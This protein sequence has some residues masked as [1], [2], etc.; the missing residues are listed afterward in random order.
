VKGEEPKVTVD[1]DTHARGA[2]VVAAKVVVVSGPDAGHEAALDDVLEIGSH[3]SCGLVLHDPAVS[4]RHVLIKRIAGKLSVKDLGSRNGTYL[5][6]AR[7]MEAEVPL[8]AVLRVGTTSIAIQP[9]WYVRELPPSQSRSFG[10]L[11]G[12]SL[13]MR[14]IFSVLERVAATGVTVLVEGESG[15]GKELA[16]RSIHSASAR[17]S[18][19]YVVFDCSAVPPE[20]AESELFGHKKGAF[21][22]AVA[23][24]AGAFMQAHRGTLFLDELGELPLELQPKILRALETGEVRAVGSDVPQRVDVRVIAATNRELHAEVQRGR[25]R[26]DL[27]Y[28]LDVVRVRMP[29]L[30]QR[31]ED[32]PGLVERLLEGKL[33][34]GDGIEGDNLA[35]L[36]AYSW[37]GNVRELRNVLARAVALAQTPERPRVSFAELVFNLGP[38][39]ASPATIG[40]DVSARVPYKVAKS[41][42]LLSFDRAYLASLLDR[43]GGN[44]TQAAAAAGLSRKHMYELIRRVEDAEADT[45]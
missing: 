7:V 22:G 21:S 8:G 11:Y 20:L 24:R 6:S 40:M 19:P 32:I 31:P 44:I 33:P 17:A 18:G 23:D 5:G 35:K 38:A 25:F 28:R 43:H 15:T 13:A 14:E 1:A 36:S 10:E 30:R 42:L 29:S 41:Q 4:R 12:D 34:P 9:R 26:E 2:P 37:P 39:S 3:A 16:A 45:A 27:L